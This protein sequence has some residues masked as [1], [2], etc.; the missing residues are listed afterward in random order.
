MSRKSKYSFK[1][2][3]WAVEQYLNGKM[4]AVEISRQLKMPGKYGKDQVTTWAHRYQ[5]SQDAFLSNA[6]YN[7]H[8][9]KEFKEKVVQ[10][11]LNGNGSL[12]SLA[13]KYGIR[14]QETVR[15]W[16]S[17]YNSHIENRDYDPHPEAHM[18]KARRKTSQP[19]RI[20]IV[21]CCLDHDKNYSQTAAKFKCS[22][23][24]VY[25]WTQKYLA[26]GEAG[27]ADK[28]GKRK[29]PE[30]L[31]ELDLANRRIKEL[32]RRL[33]EEQAKNEFL[34]KL[35]QLERMCLPDSQNIDKPQ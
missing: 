3:K 22:Y 9:S 19:E 32:E 11:Y 8:Y 21:Q 35:D 7:A 15:K 23:Q 18:T 29:Q 12:L 33:K 27:L 4:S 25:S 31:S 6:K 28:R 17:K 10:E 2:K 16:V 14:S 1:Q 34:K 24:Q 26:D 30:E 13:N 5:S 20:K